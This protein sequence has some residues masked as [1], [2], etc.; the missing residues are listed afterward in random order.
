M[1]NPQTPTKAGEAASEPEPMFYGRW[2]HGNGNLCCGSMRYFRADFD[3]N[4]APD[5]REGIFDWVCT[6]MNAALDRWREEKKAR[7]SEEDAAPS[8]A[9]R[10]ASVGA[11]SDP[12][13]HWIPSADGLS[14]R[15]PAP[16]A[17]APRVPSNP[18]VTFKVGNEFARFHPQAS[19]VSPD[20]RDGWNRCY[21][22]ALATPQALPTPQA[23]RSDT[24]RLQLTVNALLDQM[25][26]FAHCDMKLWDES[27]RNDA[28][29]KSWVQSRARRMLEDHKS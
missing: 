4:P 19:H 5:V 10:A 21:D 29:F 26:H 7:E 13:A 16:D 20:F 23:E 2:H 3:T 25:H 28:Q 9:D 15:N 18:T 12:H 8:P 27:M 17:S 22:A 1:T 11:V 6:T 24:E 14:R